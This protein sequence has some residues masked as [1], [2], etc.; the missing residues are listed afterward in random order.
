MKQRKLKPLPLILIGLLTLFIGTAHAAL[1]NKGTDFILSFLPQLSAPNIELHLT[2]DVATSVTVEYP[3]NAPTFSTTVAVAPGTVTI[4]TLPATASS[5]WGIN[6]IA[7]NAVHA[8]ASDEF[9]AYLI[10]RAPATSDAALG[11][12]VDTFNT[13]YIVATYNARFGGGEFIVYAG[14]DNTTVT[15]TP[16]NALT[17]RPA[18]VP[19]DVVL[20]RG[21][22]Y[23]G[24]SSSSSGLAGSLTGTLIS[25]DRPVGVVNG[26]Y[27]TQVPNGTTACDHI[28]EVAQP[29]QSWGNSA[30]VSNLPN[31]PSGS[32]YRIIAS[33]D[34]TDVTQD[35]VSIGT[36][37]R[38]DFIE[39]AALAGNHV[40]AGSKPIY[41][42][43]FMTG[44]SSPGATLG[45][46]AMG[47]MIPAEQYLPDYTFSTVGG[48]Q[49]AQNFLTLIANN[50]DLSTILLDGALVGAGSFTPIA[51]TSFSAATLPLTDGTHLTSSGGA[52]GITVEGYNGFDS[53]IYPGGALFE[54]INPVG[55][56]NAPICS[57]SLLAGPPPSLQGSAED[58][59][60]TEDT[61]GNG[62]LDPGEDLNGNGQI[63]EDTGV[64]FVALEPGAT[65]LSLTV[66]P[67]TPG[68]GLISF[69]ASLL[70][71][72]LPGSGVVK[73]TDGAGNFCTV[74]VDLGGVQPPAVCD[75]D[76]DGDVDRSDISLIIAARNTPA[77]GPDDPRDIDGNGTINVL[78][79][80]QC[81]QQCTNARCQ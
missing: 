31:R 7:N 50:A 22:G 16:N 37:N 48:A 4:V 10:N 35:A 19:F 2:S 71:N 73:A 29:V 61:N 14:F 15:I 68:D 72:N 36:I 60:P 20:N 75:I 18:G 42:V 32:I 40:F 17:G 58:S 44:Q 66:T 41:V 39:T 26:N 54:F 1:D 63:D 67:F 13:E 51:G 6:S 78:D 49:F 38:G 79:A 52:H 57:S 11:L 43:Q 8:F 30:L 25:A 33:E 70:D 80:R 24:R 81:T 9:V 62:V 77:S 74:D 59:R 23:H 47:N 21:E 69:N 76:A 3:V 12:P 34:G 65:N 46:P 5:A 45:D 53:Y 56:A 27:C 28:F 55:D 64:F